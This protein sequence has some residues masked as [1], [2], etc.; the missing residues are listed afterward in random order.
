VKTDSALKIKPSRRLWNLIGHPG[1]QL[2]QRHNILLQHLIS[3]SV[4]SCSSITE[5]LI[6]ICSLLCVGVKRD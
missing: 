1:G 5:S 4:P 2:G 3:L 6:Y